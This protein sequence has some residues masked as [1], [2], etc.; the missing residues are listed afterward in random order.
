MCSDPGN[1]NDKCVPVTNELS[2]PQ[3]GDAEVAAKA[4]SILAE[5]TSVAQI[6]LEEMYDMLEHW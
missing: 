2:F 3:I 6:Q 5:R 4:R 1:Y